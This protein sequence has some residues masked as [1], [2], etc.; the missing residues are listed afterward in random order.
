VLATLCEKRILYLG[1]TTQLL[2]IRCP[3]CSR[4]LCRAQI[5]GIIELKCSK[6]TTVVRIE[7][8]QT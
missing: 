5:S 6:C 3:L 1:K 7:P 8:L 4:L 2:Q